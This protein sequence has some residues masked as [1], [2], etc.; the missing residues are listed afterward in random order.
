VALEDG[1]QAVAREIFA[2][3]E[4]HKRSIFSPER[5][6]SEMMDWAMSDERLKVEMLRFVD[7]FPTLRDRS[8]ISRHLREY[9]ERQGVAAPRVLRWG[10]DLT[11]GRSPLAPLAGSVIRRQLRGFAGRF[12]IGRDARDALPALEALRRQGTGFTLDLLGEGTLSVREAEGVQRA[13]LE[14]LDVLAERARDWAPNPVVDRAAWG[15]LPRV[16]L[17]LKLTSLLAGMDPLDFEGSAAAAR[18]TLRP[19]FRKAAATGAALTIDLEQ[20]RY[21]D[22]TYTVFTSLLDEE[23]FAGYDEAGVV[24]QAYLRDAEQDLRGLL[25]WARSRGRVFHLRLVKGAYWDYETVLAAQRGWPVPVF[26]HKPDTDAMFERL[27]RVMLEHPH[28]VRP[29]FASHNVRSLAVA[30]ATARELGL[31][32]DAYEFQMLHGMGD[33]IK[34][35]VRSLGLRLREYAPVGQLIPGMAYLVRRLLENTANESFLRRTFVEG[36]DVDEL[37]RPPQASPDLDRAPARRPVIA[38][39]DPEAPGPFRNQPHA[40]FSRREDRERYDAAF[41]TVRRGLGSHHPLRVGGRDIDTT[42]RLESTDPAQP[43]Q[44]V[45]TAACAGRAEAEAAVAAARAALPAWR[46]AP[47]AERAAVLFRAAEAVRA[48]QAELAALAAFEAGMPWRDADAEVARAVDF[49]EYHGREALRLAAPRRTA[50]VPGE[51]TVLLHEAHGVA[52]ALAPFSAPISAPA[53]MVSAA[54]VSGDPVILKPAR[55]VPVIAARLVRLL[56]EAG[57]PAGTVGFLPGQ[58]DEVGD[59]LVRHEGVDLVAFTGSSETGLQVIAQAA[60]HPASAGPKRVVAQM[61]GSNAVIV[62]G[63]ADVG[64][65]VGETLRSA[66]GYAGQT[67]TALSRAVVLEGA[68]DRFVERLVDATSGLRVGP[69]EQPGVSLGPVITAEARTAVEA[70]IER[71]R[72]S[73]RLLLR[74]EPPGGGWPHGGHFVGPAVFV[75]VDPASELAQADIPGPVLAVLRARDH[76]EALALANGVRYGL[77]GALFSRSPGTI[78]RV[79]REFRVGDLFINR[80]STHPLVHRQ[81]FGGLKMS[82]FGGQAGGPDYLPQFVQSRVVSENTM[83]RGFAPPE[84]LLDGVD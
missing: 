8:E 83:R 84:E 57:A 17:S 19:I 10:I 3:T 7:V 18:E 50:V 22:L 81:P 43:D 27:T 15:P 47:A 59:F 82:G 78:E 61:G 6:Q 30:T 69:P 20:F 71:G 25:D 35:A 75:D 5:W 38:P 58:G 21:R 49:L 55:P 13:Y 45:G 52:V 24:V 77:T 60:R 74:V 1:V 80:G 12:I 9:F 2:R 11:G 48:Q 73:A 34:A 72:Q 54:L 53:C 31:R 79:R 39:T 42:R 76:D 32:D 62:D 41:E 29:A 44:S 36:A 4:E 51:H 63:D 70:V 67:Y 16:N 26:T 56:E 64:A 65:A 37:L 23:E 28:V 66:F 14:L 40:D 46:A 68:Y 33:P